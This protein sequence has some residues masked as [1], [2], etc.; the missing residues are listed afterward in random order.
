[1]NCP[2]FGAAMDLIESRRYLRCAHCGTFHFTD[3]GPAS[4]G[5]R[6]VGTPADAL[7]CAVCR[8]PMAHAVIDNHDPIDFCS[9]C[10][11]VLLP[12]TTFVMVIGRRRAW[13]VTPSVEP[14]PLDRLELGRGLS[15]PR[16]NQRFETFPHYG[17]GN[18]V[19]DNCARCDVIWLDYGEMR[20]IVDAPGR[21]RG[22]RHIPM[23]DDE[24]RSGP[25]E[26]AVENDQR[27]DLASSDP[28]TLLLHALFGRIPR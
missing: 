11:G 3:A 5:I 4:D 25:S 1:M 26:E 6:V 28:L 7:G 24:V 8:V 9:G 18:V 19:I 27:G 14:G 2:N 23:S 16:C 13:A 17:P 20:Q 21:D 10:R 12:R 22:G 15:C